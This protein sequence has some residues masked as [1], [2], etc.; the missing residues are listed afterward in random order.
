[1]SE[2]IDGRAYSIVTV[3]GVGGGVV[4]RPGVGLTK[5]RLAAERAA[6]GH[7]AAAA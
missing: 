6:M 3:G 4:A 1:M 2:A 7:W 5:K